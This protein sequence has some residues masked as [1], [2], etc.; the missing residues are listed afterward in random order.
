MMGQRVKGADAQTKK[1]TIGGARASVEPLGSN[2]EITK[3]S[4]EHTTNLY[5]LG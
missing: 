3:G 5:V 4:Q 1:K 2:D